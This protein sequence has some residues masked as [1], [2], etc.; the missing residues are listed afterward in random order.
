MSR[1]TL[2]RLIRALSVPEPG[3]VAVVGID[4][5]AFRK[6]HSY[7]G[8]VV[9][10]HTRRP[11]GLLTDRRADSFADWLRAHPG[12]HVICRDAPA[13]TPKARGSARRRRSRWPTASTCS[14]TSPKR[15][16][17]SCARTASAY[18]SSPHKKPP[19]RPR[20]RSGATAAGGPS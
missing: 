17:G 10:M 5:F 19:R 11:V 15:W 2:L 9:D 6:G 13:A 1:T 8:I 14:T 7:G 3:T 4:D 12:A 16:T 18:A 20:R